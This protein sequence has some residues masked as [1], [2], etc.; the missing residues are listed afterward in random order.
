MKMPRGTASIGGC[1]R[2]YTLL[3]I[4]IV[5]SIIVLLVGAAIPLSSGFVREQRLR[6]VV[7]E[8]LVLA[9]TARSDAMTSG[10]RAVIIFDNK[11]FGLL[12]PGDEEP[13][14]V[15]A[16][17]TGIVYDIL[18]FGT[19]RRVRPDGLRW[20]FQPSGLLEPL[21]V[22]VME[23]EAWMEVRFDPLTAALS[24]ESYHIP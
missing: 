19:D 7:R 10:G 24:D 3:E 1:V 5:V 8:I 22:R 2:G 18:P 17:P 15:Y 9:K 20:V 6:D 4:A 13:S 11:S 14:E 23:D 21:A 16:L 12:R